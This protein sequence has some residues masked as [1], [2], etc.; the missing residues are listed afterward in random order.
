M[1]I[2]S[3]RICNYIL[4]QLFQIFTNQSEQNRTL[5]FCVPY[6]NV[7]K[8][9]HTYAMNTRSA[10]GFCKEVKLDDLANLKY[11]INF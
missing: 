8:F 7:Q 5:D 11:S 4:S 1:K 10:Y 9:R 2:G 3:N 6:H